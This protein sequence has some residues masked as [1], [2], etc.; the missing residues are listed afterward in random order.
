MTDT[1]TSAIQDKKI[2]LPHQKT[3]MLA[4]LL[5]RESSHQISGGSDERP[6][7]GS[8]KEVP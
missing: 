6:M 4:I 1:L 7:K 5:W 2:F 8:G 3:E